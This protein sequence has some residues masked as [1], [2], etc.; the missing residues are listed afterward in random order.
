MDRDDSA[1]WRAIEDRLRRFLVRRVHRGN[2][3]DVLQEILLRVHRGSPQVREGER[4]SAWLYQVA[5]SAIIDDLRSRTR[6][7]LAGERAGSLSDEPVV[8]PVEPDDGFDERELAANLVPLVARLPSPYREAI[9]LVE[10]EGQSQLSAARLAG[11]SL[12]GMKSRV[13]RGRRR[14]REVV[15]A[16]CS[17]AL[18]ARGRVAAVEPARGD[19]SRLLP[20]APIDPAVLV[21]SGARS[22][23]PKQVR[24]SRTAL[25]AW[26]SANGQ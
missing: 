19:R 6:H 21:R 25:G 20:G 2:V 26:S 9:T 22:S 14:L 23:E 7:P 24:A 1:A 11:I 8:A 5:R 12:S 4:F 16:C 13:Q 3:N 15:E 18:D 10:L 17:V